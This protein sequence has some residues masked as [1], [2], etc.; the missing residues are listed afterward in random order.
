MRKSIILL[1]LLTFTVGSIAQVVPVID[2]PEYN[3]QKA[4]GTLSESVIGAPAMVIPGDPFSVGSVQPLNCDCYTEPDATWSTLQACDDCSSGLINI[5]FNFCLFGASY[6]AIYINNNGNISFGTPY[7]TFSPVVFPNNNFIMVAPFWADVDT[8]N[9]LGQVRYKITPT[10]LYVNWVNVGYYNTQGDKRNTFSVILTNNN[11]PVIG[12]GNNVA[13]CYKDMQWTTGSASGGQGGFGG[14]PALV[15]ANW[16]NGVDF[17]MIGRFNG[18]GTTYFGPNANNNQVSWLDFKS[19]KF[20]VCNNVNVP[21]ILINGVF[22]GYVFTP[23][24][25]NAIN[26]G[27]MQPNGQGNGI[28]VGQT[29]TGSL[30]FSGPE[31]NQTVTIS[32]S[33][34]P[35]LNAP[36]VSGPSPTLNISYTPTMGTNGPQTI[37]VTATDNGNPNLSTTITLVVNVTSPPYNPTISGDDFICPGGTANLMVNEFFDT[38]TWSGAAS[39]NQQAISGPN[40]TYNVTVT[41]GGCTLT[42]SKQVGLY[43]LPN[44][45]IIGNQ[46]VC[47][48]STTMLSTTI[49]FAAYQWS[50]GDMS[51]TTMAG[52]GT[53]TVTVTDDNGCVN[54]S[55]PFTITDY[56]Q[57]PIGT[58]PVNA[59]CFGFSDG[60]LTATIGGATGNETIVWDHDVNETSFTATGLSAGNYTFT[61]TDANGCQWNGSGTV[62][63]PQ[64]LQYSVAPIN[65]T[66]P[67]GSDGGA[68]VIAPSGGTTP[69]SYVWNG[70]AAL[71]GQSVTGLS[72]GNHSVVVTDANGCVLQQSFSLT[73]ISTTPQISSVPAIET[74]PGATNGSINLTVNGGSPSFTY[75]WNNGQTAE[76]PTGLGT[77]NYSVTVTDI[78]GC[79]FSHTDFVGVGE[80]LSISTIVNDVLCYG[81]SSGSIVITPQTGIAPFTVLMNGAPASLNNTNLIAGTYNFYMTDVNGCYFNFSEI[82]TQPTPLIVDSTITVINLG[83]VTNLNIFA[84]GGVPPYD[85][86][87]FPGTNLS[88]NDCTSP[89]CWAVNT[90]SYNVQVTDANG[91]VSYG[92][93]LVEVLPSSSFAPS[94]FT[95]NGDGVNDEFRVY[96]VGVK[97]FELIIFNRWGEKLFETDNIYKGWNGKSGDRL[98]EQGMYT[99]KIYYKLIS[100]EEDVVHGNFML[101]R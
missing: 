57:P 72:M 85:Y 88:C 31:N 44:P 2:S 45:I 77:G 90:T 9:N 8:R 10:A 40:G 79:T 81:N 59:S 101:L 75:L 56:I 76:D 14:T 66:C 33:G 53:H 95:P 13:F 94:A 58:V 82:I 17:N 3:T 91:C 52:G 19:F 46:E 89:M 30:Q 47:A 22:P 24:T 23:D 97:D 71:N 28:C 50:T 16:G 61:I 80:D 60:T 15:G 39:G 92:N 11:D 55:P 100:G 29:I 93:A 49:P 27:T 4:N 42:T 6:N 78:N 25:C 12:V 35:G 69:Y 48:G 62:G 98:L 18:P 36:T 73:E 96:I 7:G 26:G 38:Y 67:G 54:I 99:Y 34:P 51:P 1:L 37:T 65:V 87:W 32:A 21:P 70:N 63:E 74:C 86:Y 64:P 43:Q 68:A 41:I 20:N 84:S 83:D 5:P